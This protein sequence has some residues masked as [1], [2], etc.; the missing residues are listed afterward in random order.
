MDAQNPS[1][2]IANLR[3]LI[4]Q[5]KSDLAELTEMNAQLKI[6]LHRIGRDAEEL[7]KPSETD[8]SDDVV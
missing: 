5:M 4:E 7:S 8:S 2:Q 3:A 1:D 6:T